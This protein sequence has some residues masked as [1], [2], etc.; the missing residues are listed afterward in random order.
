[1]KA[2]LRK[3]GTL[4]AEGYSELSVF[5]NLEHTYSSAKRVILA[6]FLEPGSLSPPKGSLGKDFVK[7]GIIVKTQYLRSIRSACLAVTQVL[8]D[9]MFADGP[10]SVSDLAETIAESEQ[11]ISLSS[12]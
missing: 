8:A 6:L 7:I 4:D 10:K 1:M 2:L 5:E 11:S 3:S 9:S 12:V